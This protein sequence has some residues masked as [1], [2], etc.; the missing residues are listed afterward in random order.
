MDESG[1]LISRIED[2][3]Y[4]S[5]YDSDSFLGFLNESEASLVC[6]YLQNRHIDFKLFGGY[7]NADRVYL[8]LSSDCPDTAYPIIALSIRS[9]GKNA[10]SHRDYLGALMGMGIKRECIGDIVI[11]DDNS[12]VVFVREEISTYILSEF[13]K[14]GSMFVNVSVFDG[15]TEE[16]SNRLLEDRII[17]T[18]MRVDNVISSI[19]NCSRSQT[20][21]LINEKRVFVNFRQVSKPSYNLNCDDVVSVRGKGKF[22]IGKQIGKTKRERLILSVFRYV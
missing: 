14:V 16:F 17:V 18:S 12:A 6:S 8:S 1:L 2:L 7:K 20:L 3:I 10:L 22:I 13:T 4:L 5:E 9:K 21:D 15:D 19:I 11:I